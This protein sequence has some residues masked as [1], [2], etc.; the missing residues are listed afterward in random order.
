MHAGVVRRAVLFAG[1]CARVCIEMQ[2]MVMN[3]SSP[4][5]VTEQITFLYYRILSIKR[6][7]NILIIKLINLQFNNSVDNTKLTELK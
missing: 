6:A 1:L 4:H 7:V 5:S 2:Y 3:K